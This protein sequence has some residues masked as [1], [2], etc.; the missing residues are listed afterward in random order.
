MTPY[1]SQAIGNDSLLSRHS[2]QMRRWSTK[3]RSFLVKST[4]TRRPFS[5]LFLLFWMAGNAFAQTSPPGDLKYKTISDTI[6]GHRTVRLPGPFG[7]KRALTQLFPGQWYDL[8]QRKYTNQLL[9]WKCSRCKPKIYPD[10]NGMDTL[11]FPER[12]GV[13]T[14]GAVKS[15]DRMTSQFNSRFHPALGMLFMYFPA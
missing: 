5:A 10:A 13:T 2:K 3:S 11:R 15:Q 12:D 7:P 6:L 4:H 14:K 1:R 9:S 8:S